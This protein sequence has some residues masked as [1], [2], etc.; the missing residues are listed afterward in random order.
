MKIY[1]SPISRNKRYFVTKIYFF[2][3]N[4]VTMSRCHQ[5]VMTGFSLLKIYKTSQILLREWCGSDVELTWLHF[6]DDLDL[7][8]QHFPDSLVCHQIFN[9]PARPI[10]RWFNLGWSYI[11][12]ILCFRSGF[13]LEL[14]HLRIHLLAYLCFYNHFS[15]PSW[16]YPGFFFSPK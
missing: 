15:S 7:T 14:A 2:I 5:F 10:R 11:P 6:R 3:I 13:L 16:F 1:S 9:G 8:W 4:F 12:L